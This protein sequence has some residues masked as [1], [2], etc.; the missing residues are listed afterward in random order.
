MRAILLGLLLPVLAHGATR[1]IIPGPGNVEGP[2][3]QQK[4]E[5]CLSLYLQERLAETPAVTLVDPGWSG[6]VLYEVTGRKRVYR[7]ED[8]AK[9]VG[10]HVPMDVLVTWGAAGK[11]LVVKL[12][13]AGKIREGRFAAG[14]TRTVVLAVAKW[15]TEQLKLD[16]SALL[17]DRLGDPALFQPYYLSQC[18]L[19]DWPMNSGEKRVQALKPFFPQNTNTLLAAQM[20]RSVYELVRAKTRDQGYAKTALP[21]AQLAL[22][23][24]LG[25]P[26]EDAATDILTNRPALFETELLRMAGGAADL[27]GLDAETAAP[28]TR[29]QKL[30]ALRCLGRIKSTKGLAIVRDAAKDPAPDIRE[31][32]TVALRYYDGQV[33]SREVPKD[34]R[35]PE[36]LL[37]V[38][39]PDVV[40]AALRRI[41]PPVALDRLK[42]LANNPYDPVAQAA[43][44]ALRA[45]RPAGGVEQLRFDLATE[46]FYIRKQILDAHPELR[47][48]GCRNSDPHVRVHALKLL[49]D[50]ARAKE[51]LNDP[52]RWVR[53]HAAAML[54]QEEEKPGPPVHSI[55]GKTNLTWLCDGGADSENSPFDAYYLMSPT[56]TDVRKRAYAKGK[57]FYARVSVGNNA[58]SVLVD[59]ARR[60]M[61]WLNL[62]QELKPDVLANLDGVILGEE[63]MSADPKGL[64]ASGWPLFCH[65]AG[66]DPSTVNGDL[67]KLSETQAA[68]WRSWA[69]TKFVEG[70]NEMY[71]YIKLRYGRLRPGF[72]VGTF[73]PGQGVI[74]PADKQW[75]FDIGGIYDYKGCSRIAAYAL[76]RR[77]KTLWPERPVIW[78]SLGIGG[79]EMNPVK[80]TQKTPQQPLIGRG[81]RAYADSVAAWLA[82]ADTGWFSIWLFTPRKQSS[83]KMAGV[84]VN[85]EDVL[86][87]NPLIERALDFTFRDV[88]KAYMA[89]REPGA[90]EAPDVDLK[91]EA[92]VES[93]EEKSSGIEEVKGQVKDEKE[94]MRRGFLFYGRYVY[95]TARVFAGLPRMSA[96]PDV[97]VIHPGLSVWS[98]SADFNLPAENALSEFDYLADVDHVKDID[99][100]RYRL[101]V[102]N[103][104]APND[105]LR[106]WQQQPGHLLVT[107]NAIPAT[108][109]S[110]HVVGHVDQLTGAAT[111][112]G[113]SDKF[114]YPGFDLLTG[115][116][117]PNVGGGRSGALV[118]TNY[119]GKYAA[120][121]NGVTI[122]ADH[123]LQA[124]PVA[125]G[126]R[127]RCDGLMRS[128]AVTVEPELPAV[129]N[130]PEWILTSTSDGI[131][132]NGAATYLR[133]QKP[134]VIRPAR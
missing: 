128:G 111:S 33:P 72:G 10:E 76:V 70:F 96:K 62:E 114:N 106:Q 117:N 80:Y 71:D 25:T 32:A 53:L 126:M 47:E 23:R 75:K 21:L 69:L 79:Y 103:N 68:A 31:A 74:T 3:E 109:P 36:Q 26:H 112:W 41:K 95:D 110:R 30:G 118:T 9:Q 93:L 57:I 125:G 8:L 20:L 15:L 105:L 44:L 113:A 37:D 38:P 22:P 34:E 1:I 11:E 89:K 87:G 90:P 104:A 120:V 27:P 35:P 59:P 49:N 24:V 115:E 134:V 65:D 131:G 19:A 132:T 64:W 18:L 121:L 28:V 52:Y 102:L 84:Q 4:L 99:L 51:A 127:V 14:P 46:H 66:I 17:A 86:P 107:T 43:R 116:L 124:E 7:E 16:S 5:I 98:R 92:P 82:G 13:E 61:F 48:E 2:N 56:I 130:V 58:G 50:P 85:V 55:Q 133:S 108:G 123:P 60:D 94:R 40:I 100:S 129:A 83:N 88:D 101:I 12:H 39:D 77:Y 67:E 63:T 97:L 78:L 45:Y 54:G 122:F 29:E 42:A 73:L 91:P 6:T 81:D 119:I